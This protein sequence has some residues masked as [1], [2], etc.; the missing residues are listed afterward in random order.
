M[1][2]LAVAVEVFGVFFPHPADEFPY[3]FTLHQA[4]DGVV[5]GSQFALG[6]DRMDL[7]VADAMHGHGV[8]A[9]MASGHHVMLVQRRTGHHGTAAQGAWRQRGFRRSHRYSDHGHGHSC[10]AAYLGT[11]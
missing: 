10:H 11:V 6:K 4:F 2:R 8:A 9:A 7:A 1:R 5:I 3:L